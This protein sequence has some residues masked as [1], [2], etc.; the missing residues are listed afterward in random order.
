MI[1]NLI[2]NYGWS[3]VLMI[4]AHISDESFVEMHY[5]RMCKYTRI[6]IQIVAF[7]LGI[8]E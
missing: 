4:E 7:S 1:I 5:L 2:I 8:H 6:F 3:H